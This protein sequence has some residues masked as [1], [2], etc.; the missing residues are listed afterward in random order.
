MDNGE[1]LW[2]PLVNPAK[3]SHQRF[4]ARNIRGFGLMQRDRAFADYED[5]FNY[6]QQVPSVWIEP[7]GAWGEGE[8][9]LVELSTQYEGLDNIVA[10]W[11]PKTKPVPMQPY[12]FAY[13]LYWTRETDMKGLSQ[14]KVLATRV[15]ADPRD[16]RR[17]QF[18]I[19]F[20][21]PGLDSLPE[22]APPQPIASCSANAAIVENQVFRNPFN[23]AWRVMLK[24]EPKA[25]NADP[26]D[27][28]CTLKKGE[29]VV[30]ETWTY[31]WSPP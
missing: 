14:N 17:R 6:Y 2:R 3:M 21:G 22:S 31:L 18:A 11:D 25:G 10:F 24:L 19:D 5:L 23:K 15:G 7:R 9:N 30:S 13:T 16:A 28:R 8:V 29:E 27:I 12:R 1:V 26:V 20:G 4:A